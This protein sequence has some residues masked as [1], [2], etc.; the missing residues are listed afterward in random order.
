MILFQRKLNKFQWS[1]LRHLRTVY[2]VYLTGYQRKRLL[3][4]AIFIL[5]L[6]ITQE[7]NLHLPKHIWWQCYYVHYIVVK[8]VHCKQKELSRNIQFYI[9]SRTCLWN[10]L[11]KVLINKYRFAKDMFKR[12]QKCY[13]LDIDNLQKRCLKEPQNVLSWIRVSTCI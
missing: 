8:Y 12:T 3:E 4:T 6:T 5:D 7:L 13:L 9:Q 11:I 2:I 10:L 1:S